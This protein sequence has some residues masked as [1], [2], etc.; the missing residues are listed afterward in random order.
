M[1]STFRAKGP[2]L[3]LVSGLFLT[4]PLN[5]QTGPLFHDCPVEGDA[6]ATTRSDPDLNV[7][8]NRTT[9]AA[10]GFKSMHLDDLAQLDVPDGVSKKHRT[11]WPD[12]TLNAVKTEEIKAV[13][14]SGFLLKKKLEGPESPN[15]HSTDKADRDFHIWLANSADD[16]KA[17]AI[18]VE[19]T[20]RVRAE[21][22]SWTSA[23]IQNLI[24]S[25]TRV[26]I[27]GW[28][29]LD[30]EHP[31]QVGKTRA[32]IWEI[33]PILKIEASVSGKWQEF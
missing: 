23:K 10:D 29:L 12:E 16:E 30:P 15:C 1:N 19:I 2:I 28:I 27:S 26:R 31:D 8:K 18:V 33:H 3:L 24:T 13:Q 7:L 9:P 11:K 4:L 14:V 21:H 25:K 17:D 20:P 6:T 22:P 32:T 5:A